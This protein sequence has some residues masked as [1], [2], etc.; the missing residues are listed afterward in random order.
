M[1]DNPA[2]A[3][4]MHSGPAEADVQ[5]AILPHFD[6]SFYCDRY[7]DIDTDRVDPL[8]HYC[9]FGWK[10]GRDPCAWFSTQRY[11]ARNADVAESGYNPFLHYV[12]V[13]RKEGRRIWPADHQGA[14]DLDVDP[15][16][17]LVLDNELRDLIKF[18]PRIS[19]GSCAAFRPDCLKIHWVVPD[20]NIGSGGHMTIFRLIRWLEIAGHDC[21]V[22]ITNPAQHRDAGAAYDDIIK[23]FQTIR[24][25]VAFADDGFAEAAGDAVVATGWQTAA[26]VLNATGF[27]QR[28]YLVQDYEPS[29]HPVGSHALA[30]VWTYTQDLACICASPW[31]ARILRERH[32]RWVS[33]FSLAYDRA[34]YYPAP[35]GGQRPALRRKDDVPHIAL[36]ARLTSARRAVELAFLALEYLAAKGVRFHVDLFGEETVETVAPFPCSGHGVLSA[37]G[38]A[39]LYRNAHIGIC[40]SATNYSLVPQE[41]MA[42]GLPVVE[43]D[44]ESTRAV[45]PEDVVT[46]TG[47]HPCAI[48]DGIEALL[49]DPERRHRQAAAALRWVDQFDWE[50]SAR[51]VEQALLDR[52]AAASTQM[53]AGPN[54]AGSKPAVRPRKSRAARVPG[55]VR[56]P[57]VSVCIPTYNGGAR[58]AEVIERVRSQRAPWRFEI[59]V[60][61]S[62]STDG[63]TERLATA[64]DH[65][66]PCQPELRLERIP[67]PEFQH[68]RTRN[69]CASL[70]R[71]EF[72]AFL[73][74]DALPTDE[75]WLYN[76]V[77]VLERFPRAAG[78]FGRHFSW[79]A[80]S[81]FT[82]RDIANHFDDLLRHPI[83]LSRGT[84]LAG[85]EDGTRTARQVLHFF[86]DNNSCLRR[87]VWEQ[88]AYPEIDYGE[89][90]AWA[91]KII[92]LGYE[93]V[94]VPSA[95]VYHSHDYTPTQITDRAEVESY[96][97]ATV[98]GYE[99]YD[100]KRTFKE[101]LAE[102][103][104]ADIRWAR[105]N[106]I[107]DGDL[108]QRLLENKAR[109]YGR[110]LGM[111]RARDA[112]RAARPIRAATAL[113]AFVPGFNATRRQR[114][115]AAR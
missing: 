85:S 93:K 4:S 84:R 115:S 56:P 101:Q 106:A 89:D 54:G 35:Q 49:R 59:I 33:Q 7:R 30:A 98:F 75:F 18:P 68:G 114:T 70:A 42:C 27:R 14:F 15:A 103:D 102:A 66:P 105:N 24:A 72:V 31:L 32:G 23:H 28:F 71:G 5:K 50:K 1:F 63:S 10:E 20:F 57:K 95:A 88:V 107:A 111:E 9:V 60:V 79:P 11:M 22:W 92:R 99:T 44:G 12:L 64:Q 62:N 53:A 65:G 104:N 87:S 58:L 19:A 76:L 91:D 36:Y 112:T 83:V 86:S 108:A 29:F 96:F 8:E 13:G 39:N 80:A 26:R 90:Q 109:L 45:F 34:I 38:L 47:P 16:A 100:F 6:R 78:A 74:Q 41:M 69:L 2:T 67:K 61:D 21:A 94:Y 110:A 113:P 52:L 73:T 97:F 48:A 46:L 3:V 81:P 77:T 55:V 43:I 82:R 17:T 51:S 40:F 25:P 37:E